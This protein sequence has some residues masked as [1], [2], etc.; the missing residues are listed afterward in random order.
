MVIRGG[1]FQEFGWKCVTICAHIKSF[2]TS[3]T[4]SVDHLA[5]F[6]VGTCGKVSE[7]IVLNCWLSIWSVRKRRNFRFCVLPGVPSR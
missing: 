1:N 6:A 2:L 7:E 4:H 3:S 5:M